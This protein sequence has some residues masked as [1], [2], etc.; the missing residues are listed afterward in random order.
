MYNTVVPLYSCFSSPKKIKENLDLFLI[1]ITSCYAVTLLV[2][3]GG[4]ARIGNTE[5]CRWF[6]LLEPSYFLLCLLTLS[7]TIGQK[8]AI[9]APAVKSVSRSCVKWETFKF[10]FLSGLQSVPNITPK[11]PPFD[12]TVCLQKGLAKLTCI[13]KRV[14]SMSHL[15]G[16]HY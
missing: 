16:K 11:L 13:V 7:R 8:T 6:A 9:F 3:Y 2:G 10:K 1:K 5:V 4:A 12:L 14:T 15:G